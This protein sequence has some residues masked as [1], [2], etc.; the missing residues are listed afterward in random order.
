VR[1][2]EMNRLGVGL[3]VVLLVAACGG[4]GESV[5]FVDLSI[6]QPV[7]VAAE[8]DIVPLRIAVAAVL[9]PEGNVENYAD[10][11]RYLGDRL[12]RPAELVQRRTY[13]E[14]N[15]LV[16][17]GD[18][19]LAFVCTSAYVAGEARSEMDLLVVPVVGGEIVYYSSIIVPSESEATSLSDLRG[20]VFAFTDPMSHTGRVYPTYALQ[21]LGETPES[22]FLS[23]FFTYS[24]DRAIEAVANGLASGAAV[25]S[26][27]LEYALDRDPTL[28]DRIRVI[29]TSPPFGIPPVVV[30]TG[31]SPRL[32]ADLE[33]L[34][35]GLESDPEGV[36]ILKKLGTDRFVLGEDGAYDG[37]RTLVEATGVGP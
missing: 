5:P 14:V 29:E 10:L 11:A 18:V 26:L 25:D 3:I 17:A 23:T 28:R 30:P 37:V 36:A 1:N 24:H 19:D 15:A 32:R 2:A 27:V 20:T 6:R 13:A 21:L 12:G 35:L 33:L 7:M 8:S 9:S 31:L 22:F 4:S 16:A 34:L